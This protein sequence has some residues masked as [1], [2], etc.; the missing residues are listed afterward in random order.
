MLRRL[1][2]ILLVLPLFIALASPQASARTSGWAIDV[3][4]PGDT[5]SR[6]AKR[7]G[8]TWQRLA[9]LNGLTRPEVVPGQ[10]LIVPRPSLSVRPGDTLWELAVR[11]GTSVKAL[12]Q[13]NGL[14]ADQPLVPG[15]RLRIPQDGRRPIDAGL[16]FVPSG[17]AAKDRAL[18]ARY[19]STVRRVGLFDVRINPNGSLAVRAFGPATTVLRTQGQLPYPVLTNLTPSGFDAAHMRRILAHPAKRRTLVDSIWHLLKANRF[20]GVMLDIEGLKPQDRALYTQFLREL[21][22]KL[23]PSG[24][25]IA[26]SVPPKQGPHTPAHAGGYDYAAIGKYADRVFVMAYDWHIP[27]FTGPGPVAPYPQVKATMAYASTVISPKKLYLGIPMY[28]Y[29]WNV[30]AGNGRALS[31][32]KALEQAIARGATIRFDPRSRTPYYRYTANGERHEVWFEDARSL[33]AKFALVKRY[34]WAGVGGWQMNLFFPQGET[35]FW[36]LFRAL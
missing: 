19:R 34:K 2:R 10:A 36:S 25:E 12:R 4:Q 8:T 23:R 33:A 7:H 11:H 5:L 9:Q 6:V 31:Q 21:H 16:F 13:V 30:T 29:D 17:N 15:T 3:V 1:L 28:G 32:Q 24:M 22:A 26:V 20:P 27:P 18:L 14:R 35:L